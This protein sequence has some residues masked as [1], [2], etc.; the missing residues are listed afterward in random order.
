M[1]I[2]TILE[3]HYSPSGLFWQDA[4]R[5]I[6]AIANNDPIRVW[7]DVSGFARHM[8]SAINGARPLLKTSI[9]NSRSAPLFDGVDDKFVGASAIDWR[10]LHNGNPFVIFLVFKTATN[11]PNSVQNLI[12]NNNN[13]GGSTGLSIYLNDTVSGE[14]NDRVT[15]YQVQAPATASARYDSSIGACAS[16]AWHVLAV[17]FTGLTLQLYVDGDVADTGNASTINGGYLQTDP[18][19]ALYLGAK[20]VNLTN[21]FL[22]GYLGEAKFYSGLMT[23]VDVLSRSAQIQSAWGI[24]GSP[25]LTLSNRVQI[26][27]SGSGDSVE[28]SHASF[29]TVTKCPN[30][31]Y[32]TIFN[33]ANLHGSMNP[34]S[35]VQRRSTDGGLTWSSMA[36]ETVFQDSSLR[37]DPNCALSTIGSR[38]WASYV[39]V[40]NNHVDDPVI[41]RKTYA[42]Y[43]DDNCVT[44][45]TPVWVGTQGYSLHVTSAG[46]IFK[47]Q[48]DNALLMPVY[49]VNVGESKYDATLLQSLDNGATWSIR[50]LIAHYE[51][52]DVTQYE[53]PQVGYLNDGRLMALVRVD[54]DYTIRVFYSSDHGRTWTSQVWGFAG[55][56]WPSW[57]QFASG[58]ILAISRRISFPRLGLIADPND[59]GF[60]RIS[61]DLGVTWTAPRPISPDRVWAYNYC[62]MFEKSPGVAS[63]VHALADPSDVHFCVIEYV[64]IHDE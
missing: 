37:G 34:S 5:T 57:I 45:S 29:P 38:V 64:E 11:N 59:Y 30:G 63:V 46:P 54:N 24:A 14:V 3:A 51:V 8:D 35:L 42:R 39:V 32:V 19:S 4:A 21:S 12:G 23:S 49:A 47:A 18:T 17:H 31:D 36:Q 61:R 6:P 13:A 62:G 10:F 22:S 28:A 27:A 44:W 43:S 52:P 25:T 41:T 15:L 20:G 40:D 60:Y 53:E 26:T 58:N 7:D 56:G 16:G 50:G 48:D 33:R 55:A 2:P 1:G 9:Q